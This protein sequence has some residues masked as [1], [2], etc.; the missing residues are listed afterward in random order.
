MELLPYP[1]SHFIQVKLDW[2]ELSCLANPYFTFRLAELRNSIENLDNF[3]TGNIAEEDAKVENEIQKILSQYERRAKVLGD[4]YPFTF[5]EE[6]QLF[7]MRTESLEELE[8]HHHA[9]IYCLY[10]SHITQSRLFSGLGVTTNAHR[11]LLQ[12]AATVALAGY[13]RGHSISFG[14]PRPDSSKFYDCL[15]RV[16]AL[17]KEGRVKAFGDVNRYLQSRPHKDAGID[18]IAWR[19]EN[20]NDVDPGN[21]H[22]FFAQV[23][24]GHNWRSKP[25][26]EDIRVIQ[27]YWLEQRLFRVTDAIVIPFDFEQ[28]DDEMKRDEISLVADEFGVVIHR[29]RLPQYFRAGLAI[30]AEKPELLIERVDEIQS[31]GEYVFSM[32]T[33]L[34]GEAA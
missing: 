11:D 26:K 32:T 1:E 31:I 29:T 30:L 6:D 3:S 10:F 15:C 5:N 7:E 9:Y 14:W 19:D 16:I 18:V 17:M 34:Q 33:T 8:I 2:V 23:A 21:K 13:V 22:I 20:P 28:D 12:I 27:T 4:T 25:V 24:S